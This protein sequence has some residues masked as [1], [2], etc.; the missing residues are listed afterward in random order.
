MQVEFRVEY[1]M[2]K[3]IV[4]NSRLLILCGDFVYVKDVLDLS[5]S[6][7]SCRSGQSNARYDGKDR[8]SQEYM[9]WREHSD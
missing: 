6:A 3:V 9:V 7:S 4:L 2:E 1:S 5:G 8:E